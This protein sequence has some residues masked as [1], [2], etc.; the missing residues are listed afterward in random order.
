MLLVLPPLYKSVTPMLTGTFNLVHGFAAV[1]YKLLKVKSFTPW[2]P[3][4]ASKLFKS[5]CQQTLLYLSQAFTSDFRVALLHTFFFSKLILRYGKLFFM[6]FLLL[7]GEI[8]FM[9]IVNTTSSIEIHNLFHCLFRRLS[10]LIVK[11]LKQFRY[12]HRYLVPIRA[13]ITDYFHLSVSS[14]LLT[15]K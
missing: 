13:Y 5:K 12:L 6:T 9:H 7:L 1:S 11:L 3:K 10:L 15:K 14:N 4:T 8:N 2:G